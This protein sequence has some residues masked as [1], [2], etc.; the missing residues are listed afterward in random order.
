MN[1]KIKITLLCAGPSPEKSI[2]LNSS[3]SVLDNLEKKFFEIS[4]IYFNHLKKPYL[5][6]N[7]AI[8]SNTVS[9]FDFKIDKIG[10]KLNMEKLKK[11]LKTK[12]FVWPLIHGE[13]GEDGEIQQFLEKNKINF[14]GTSSKGSAIT[15]DKY[16]CQ[17]V[18]KKNGFY[19]WGTR[20]VD[21]TTDPS[22][23]KKGAYV[24]KPN[25]GGSS[26][27][28]EF[29]NDLKEFKEKFKKVLSFGKKAVLEKVCPGKEFTLIILENQNKEPIPL[30][31]TE[32]EFK[33]NDRFFNYRKKYL[34]S[35][36]VHFHNPPRFDQKTIQKINS[37]AKKAFKTL[38]LRDYARFDGWVMPDGQIWFSDINSVPGMEQNS[39]VFRQA[40][41]LGL[42][43]CDLLR[44][45]LTTAAKRFKI[46]IPKPE[47]K[48]QKD[49]RKKVAVIFGGSTAE[50]Q[51]SLLSGT[52][53]W[54]KL[55]SSQNYSPFPI[56][57]DKKHNFWQIPHFFCLHHTVEE[58]EYLIE[59]I[60]LKKIKKFQ[61]ISKKIIEELGIDKNF[62][63]EPLFLPKKLKLDQVKQQFDFIF[64][65][66]HGGIGEDGTLQKKLEKDRIPFNGPGSKASQI[67]MD[68]YKTAQ[69]INQ[70]KI[71][72]LRALEKKLIVIGKIKDPKKT[73]QK[74]QKKFPN[75]EVL[76]KPRNDGCSAGVVKLND[77]R[78]FRIYLNYIRKK[79]SVL[80]GGIM[81][82][83]PEMIDLPEG[84]C[85]E[86]FVEE[87]I[88][89]DK[90][91]IF[92]NKINWKIK[93]GWI[94][95]S[96]GVYGNKKIK[97]MTPSQTIA[98]GKI[99]TIEE[100]F[101]GGTGV[102]FTPPYEK[103][104]SKDLINK[105]Q[106][107]VEKAAEITKI[108]GYCRTDCF[109][110][111]KT[112]ELIIIENNTLPALTPSTIIYHQ[113]LHEKPRLEPLPF[114][115]KLID[116]GFKRYKIK[117]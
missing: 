9:D 82:D 110:N 21:K 29:V 13:L 40:G 24:L 107:L 14:I 4:I 53:V 55:K 76:I 102:N 67:G 66:L 117:D 59:K 50:R 61:K 98:S 78:E 80:P 101:Q 57:M 114:I 37:Q 84:E 1:K 72:N 96:V 71:K 92:N 70:A 2:S 73:W 35:D 75:K 81:M 99:L 16:Q 33:K 18:L 103:F 19:V 42:N 41:F 12:D 90:I 43:H 68:K 108:K 54:I 79:E 62:L 15:F 86:F 8:Y 7:W 26:I 38:K 112:K 94:E 100:K 10:K 60:N 6:P 47:R 83:H 27:G 65:G 22:R 44:F 34:A 25:S 49:K 39:F 74:I 113:A 91:N 5:I 3:R 88:K 69:L 23:I 58:I 95:I 48:P 93:S 106:K 28:V 52:N 46:K 85:G 111:I 56:L 97:A 17:Q 30:I 87:F 36:E 45:F 105:A 109:L 64:L 31:P 115:E 32:I 11:Y 20:L 51:I 116:L 63:S 104:L 77:F 89:V